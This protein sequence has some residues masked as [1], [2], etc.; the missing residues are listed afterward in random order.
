MSW[1]GDL[2]DFTQQSHTSLQQSGSGHVTTL[3]TLIPTGG[4]SDGPGYGK[5]PARH[6]SG[7]AVP[8]TARGLPRRLQNNLKLQHQQQMIAGVCSC[9]Y[10]NGVG[11]FVYNNL[12]LPLC[13]NG[14]PDILA[15][16]SRS[17]CY[18]REKWFWLTALGMCLLICRDHTT[19]CKICKITNT[20][21]GWEMVDGQTFS[22]AFSMA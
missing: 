19:L 18:A 21:V 3:P 20:S 22:P 17:F 6:P 10:R 13:Q 5:L 12:L 4:K 9:G 1:Y 7:R 15:S 16:D 11:W 8:L 14:L 2:I